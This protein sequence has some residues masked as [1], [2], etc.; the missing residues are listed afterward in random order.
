MHHIRLL[1]IT[2][3]IRQ[4][5]QHLGNQSQRPSRLF[6][7][8]ILNQHIRLGRH[9]SRINIPQEEKSSNLSTYHDFCGVWEFTFRETAD[10]FT[11][12]AD[13]VGD[14]VDTVDDGVE[15]GTGQLH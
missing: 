4:I 11:D 7:R 15:E 3:F 13:S 2:R 1:C 10:L 5:L 8:T 9:D 12:P 14:L 6:L